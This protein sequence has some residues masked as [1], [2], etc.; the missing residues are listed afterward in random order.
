M[1]KILIALLLIA[2][3]RLLIYLLTPEQD[4]DDAIDKDANAI[5]RKQRKNRDN[6]EQ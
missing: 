1:T 3:V 4:K 5:P 6:H 2:L